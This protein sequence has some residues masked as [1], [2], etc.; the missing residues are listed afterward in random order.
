MVPRRTQKKRRS[1]AVGLAAAVLASSGFA[2]GCARS[3]AKPAAPIATADAPNATPL[4]A[5]AAGRGVA[6]PPPGRL[7]DSVPLSLRRLVREQRDEIRDLNALAGVV[8]DTNGRSRALGDVKAVADELASIEAGLVPPESER[9][10]VAASKLLQLET[11]IAL[12]HET[13]R[14]AHPDPG[15]PKIPD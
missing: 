3:A 7:N 1:H 4:A 2:A 10:D 6:A 11:K 8:R 9:L 5:D 12:L 15:S 13:L 14:A